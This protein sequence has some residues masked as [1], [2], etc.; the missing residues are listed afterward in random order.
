[1]NQIAC[2]RPRSLLLFSCVA[3]AM[4]GMIGVS[5]AARPPEPAAHFFGLGDLPGG[6]TISYAYG[7]SGSGNVIAGESFS[8]ISQIHGEG[9]QW[10]R[11]S[12]T[13]WQMTGIGLPAG[14]ALNSPAASA[15][16]DGEWI[17][18][19]VSYTSPTA[20][21]IDTDAYRWRLSTGFE[22][23][24]VPSGFVVAAALGA[25]KHG[26][27]IVGWGG[28]NPSYSNLRALAWRRV[29][30]NWQV[31]LIEPQYDSLAVR[32]DP[33]G[34]IAIGWGNSPAAGP[35]GRE[36]VYWTRGLAGSWQRHW[37]GA[38]PN[39]QFMSQASG[40][41]R[42][43]P[44]HLIVGFSG[45]FSEV[46]LPTIWRVKGHQLPQ[47]AEL[48]LLPGCTS[49][50]ANAISKDGSRIVG[51]CWDADFVFQA[52][53]WD[54]VPASGSYVVSNLKDR[55]SALGVTA[56]DDWTLWHTS[57]VSEDGS[58]ICGSGTNPQGD[59]EGWAADLP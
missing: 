32:V 33:V 26:H 56:A 3:A 17:V 14:D 10:E 12:P 50:S 49:G 54:Y 4:I 20:P 31:E 52:S 58:V 24:G 53:V 44:N 34:R 16:A 35:S 41:A 45:V 40:I 42:V 1:M 21:L 47:I 28:P 55:L 11:L 5:M 46:I 57:G 51:N 6:A 39:T 19:R 8:A 13:S 22:L 2:S 27:V 48:P 43:G 18:G 7:I 9:V 30:S 37:L 38:L 23:L 59:Q 36:A 29:A 15:S 25:D